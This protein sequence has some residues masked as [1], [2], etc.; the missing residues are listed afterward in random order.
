MFHILS[1]FRIPLLQLE[2][3]HTLLEFLMESDEE[4]DFLDEVVE[5]CRCLLVVDDHIFSEVL[6]SYHNLVQLMRL[7]EMT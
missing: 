1:R 3:L 4:G 7:Q 2:F 6:E 5:L